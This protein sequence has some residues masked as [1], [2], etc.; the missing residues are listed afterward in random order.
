VLAAGC[1]DKTVRP[2]DPT[3]GRVLG[4]LAGHR[5]VVLR[6]VHG[7]AWRPEA[8]TPASAGDAGPVRL[9]A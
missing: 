9:W 3:D 2:W 6:N 8:R 4:S 7:V 1:T 5:G